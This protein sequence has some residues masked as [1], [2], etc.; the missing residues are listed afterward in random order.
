MFGIGSTELLL[1]LGIALLVIGPKKLPQLARTLGKAMGE[2]KKVSNDVKRTIDAEVERVERTES[3]QRSTAELKPEDAA[4][5]ADAPSSKTDTAEAE[6][7]A[8]SAK[9]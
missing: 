3:R 2:F 1:I 4:P 9:A 6:K 7:P 5:K 8:E